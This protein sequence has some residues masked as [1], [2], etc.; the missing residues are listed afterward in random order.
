MTRPKGARLGPMK[1]IP[2]ICK[3]SG[4]SERQIALRTDTPPDK[5]NYWK[6]HASEPRKLLTFICR[7]RKLSGLSWS[8]IGALL[9]EEFLDGSQ[10]D[11]KK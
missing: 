7:L 9:D 3:L 5:V 8:K 2:L 10:E 11:K 1:F 4:L 6:K